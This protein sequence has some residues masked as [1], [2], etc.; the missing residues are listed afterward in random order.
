MANFHVSFVDCCGSGCNVC[1]WDNY[2]IQ[3]E[4]YEQLKEDHIEKRRSLKHDSSIEV[5]FTTE[6]TTEKENDSLSA[7]ITERAIFDHRNYDKKYLQL[8]LGSDIPINYGVGSII[9]IFP[10]NPLEKV[11]LL[12]KK[13][14]Y[15]GDELIVIESN[16]QNHSCFVE[17]SPLSLFQ[18]FSKYV[19][20]SSPPSTTLLFLLSLHTKDSSQRK[21]LIHL[22]STQ[23][24]SQY[25]QT[26]IQNYVSIVDTLLNFTYCTP[27]LN[28]LLDH[29]PKMR[30]R[31]YSIA[32]LSNSDYY[33]NDNKNS[34]LIELI[35][36]LQYNI[37]DDNERI[38]GLSSSYLHSLKV[39][40]KLKLEIEGNEILNKISNSFK[41]I[42]FCCHGSAIAAYMSLIKDRY[43]KSKLNDT[44][45]S[46]YLFYG[47][48][49][50]D[51]YLYKNEIERM[52]D[53]VNI[54][55]AASRDT[56]EKVYVANTLIK[57]SYVVFNLLTKE[58]AYLCVCGSKSFS[59][60][61]TNAIVNILNDNGIS[62]NDYINLMRETGR[63]IEECW[64]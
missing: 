59:S 20:L 55:L 60:S 63:H 33:K 29:L 62:G 44:A 23:G 10:E 22:S 54:I 17:K 36:S 58:D 45:S 3:L 32:S 42:I 30:Q 15:N 14:G 19:D 35:V 21:Q 2:Y 1:V 40:D 53:I 52:R 51:N 7:V 26:Y 50:S 27:P 57:H 64:D 41:P 43:Y 56:N 34:D 9:K 6:T 31:K 12:M 48:H 8:T 4:K 5:V 28:F 11:N 49:H 24:F 37:R 61:V 16:N 39:K 18:L 25:Q 47:V 46:I 13:L 38:T